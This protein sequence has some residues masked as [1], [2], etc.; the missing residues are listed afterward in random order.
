MGSGQDADAT[1]P[2]SADRDAPIGRQLAAARK[3]RKLDVETV[4]RELKLDAA[5]VRALESDD[6]TAL[7]APIFVQGYLRSYARLLD[8][9]VQ[10]LLARY[11]ETTAAPP[12]LTV[13]RIKRKVPV[14]QMPSTRLIRNVVL[15]LLT[16]IMIWL[17]YPYVAQLLTSRDKVIE[18]QAPGRL[19]LPPA[20]R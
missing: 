5:I 15:V 4:A 3:G 13:T 11:A 19:E 16:G 10:E 17:A 6:R 12:P 1:T 18:E 14:L 20:S 9:P 7:P 8:L 2:A